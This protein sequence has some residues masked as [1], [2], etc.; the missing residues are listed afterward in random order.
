MAEPAC[1]GSVQCCAIRVALLELDGVPLPGASNLY[2]ADAVAKVEFQAQ[3]VKGVDMES[4]SACGFPA[5][6]YKDMDRFKRY[7]VTL[8]LQYLDPE[9]ENLLL[10]T[11]LFNQGGLNI[12][13]GSPYVAAYAGYFPG[14]S[15][16][17]WSKHIV[18]GDQDPVYPYIQWVCPR[19]KF[20]LAT[21]VTFE[22]NPMVRMFSG[23]T[24]SN[25]NWYHGPEDDW[26]FAS[27]TQLAW[28]MCATIPTPEC[29][30]QPLVAT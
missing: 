1:G 26:P 6:L 3:V 25:P 9:L 27:D 17:L 13:G 2:I 30:A 24:S 15:L 8:N 22:N 19:V 10:G 4:I 5:I 18:N 20:S 28:R 14:V 11:E 23:F 29:G 7:D 16:E 12:G 21:P